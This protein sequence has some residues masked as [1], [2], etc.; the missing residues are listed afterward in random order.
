MKRLKPAL[1]LA[2]LLIMGCA[3]ASEQWV[4][5]RFNQS[6]KA[7]GDALRWSE[8]ETAIAFRK[9]AKELKSLPDIGQLKNIKVTS[10]EVKRIVVWEK[11][12]RIEQIVE[13]KYYEIDNMLEKTCV[14]HQLWEYDKASKSWYLSSDLPELN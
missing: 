10:Y 1:L 2:V 6:T 5:K 8:Y 12:S 4:M 3:T 11:S 7:Y 9:G 13:I 14:D